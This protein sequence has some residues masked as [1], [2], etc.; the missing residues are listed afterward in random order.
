M[1]TLNLSLPEPMKEW[2]EAQARSGRFSDAGEYLR[3]LIQ[4]DRE[5]A[6]ARAELERLVA[7]GFDS[8][9]SEL[10][11]DDVLDMARREAR[12]ASQTR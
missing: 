8:G 9:V 1:A 7:E 5:T 4:R 2:V 3:A 11:M 12:I 10:S 6:D